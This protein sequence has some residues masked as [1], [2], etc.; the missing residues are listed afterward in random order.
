MEIITALTDESVYVDYYFNIQ[1]AI[2]KMG[3]DDDAL[4]EPRP[5]KKPKKSSKKDKKEKGKDKKE[6]GKEGWGTPGDTPATDSLN[7]PVPADSLNIK[8]TADSID[9]PN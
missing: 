8:V 3:G 1:H 7:I 2:D 9:K 4:N 6:K 5:V